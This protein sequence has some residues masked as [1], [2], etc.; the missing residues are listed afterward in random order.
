MDPFPSI[1]EFGAHYNTLC[2]NI[3]ELR[4]PLLPAAGI[5]ASL[6]GDR[7][8]KSDCISHAILDESSLPMTKWQE[9]QEDFRLESLPLFSNLSR[10]VSSTQSVES[11]ST[12][13]FRAGEDIFV[14]GAAADGMVVLLSGEAVLF[15]SR[16]RWQP[17]ALGHPKGW[18]KHQPGSAFHRSDAIGN[19]ARVTSGLAALTLSR[20]NFA[21]LLNEHPDLSS[22]FGLAGGASNAKNQPTVCRTA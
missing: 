8:K 6:P 10:Q 17:K 1:K 22:A 5:A 9:M 14:Q 16:R 15:R 13:V 19:D 12:A 21:R 2:Q 18:T 20:T 7:Q 4:D 11:L 3:E